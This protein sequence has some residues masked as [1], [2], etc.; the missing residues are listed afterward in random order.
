MV[1]AGDRLFSNAAQKSRY[2]SPEPWPTITDIRVDPLPTEHFGIQMVWR[3]ATHGVIATFPWWD[4]LERNA[5]LNAPDWWPVGTESDHYVD[6]EQDWVFESRADAQFVYVVEG[7]D[8]A[9][10]ERRYRVRRDVFLAAWRDGVRRIKA[11]VPPPQVDNEGASFSTI[12]VGLSIAGTFFSGI[13]F[14]AYPSVVYAR[15]HHRCRSGG[16]WSA[17]RWLRRAAVLVPAALSRRRVA[18]PLRR[19]RGPL[20]PGDAHGRGVALRP[21]AHRLDGG[22]DLRA[23]RSPS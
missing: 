14:I 20:R 22:D 5:R 4:N 6:A 16:C 19:A 8:I 2:W 9:T 1:N 11:S 10:Y 3:S 13:S 12:V 7:L 23:R 18:V 17:C 15:R 21:H